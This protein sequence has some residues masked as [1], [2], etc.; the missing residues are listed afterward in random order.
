M[1]TGSGMGGDF[2]GPCLS[3]HSFDPAICTALLAA[4]LRPQ[5]AM[6]AS[7][8]GGQPEEAGALAQA[9][10]SAAAAVE[11][12]AEAAAEQPAALE[13]CQAGTAAAAGEAP[14]AAAAA[15]AIL[16]LRHPLKACLPQ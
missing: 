2:A 4:H 6:S 7:E 3:L 13:G 5:L 14:A 8:L 15:A 9:S 1:R 12:A 16:H 10:G 11:A